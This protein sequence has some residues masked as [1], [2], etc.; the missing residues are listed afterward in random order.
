MV[1]VKVVLADG[2]E[3]TYYNAQAYVGGGQVLHVVRTTSSGAEVS[4][5]I[6][7]KDEYRSWDS[8][9]VSSASQ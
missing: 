5:G 3:K 9:E 8:T 6:L 4:L 1:N 7:Q 2:R